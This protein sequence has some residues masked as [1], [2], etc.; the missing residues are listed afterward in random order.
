MTEGEHLHFLD[1]LLAAKEKTEK[2]PV[3][4]DGAGEG[5]PIVQRINNRR[6]QEGRGRGESRA[7]EAFRGVLE[8]PAFRANLFLASARYAKLGRRFCNSSAEGDTSMGLRLAN[9]DYS[10]ITMHERTDIE[11]SQLYRQERERVQHV[12]D[13]TQEAVDRTMGVVRKS[14]FSSD[15]R[16]ACREMRSRHRDLDYAPRFDPRNPEIRYL[17]LLS[18]AVYRFVKF[19]SRGEPIAVVLRVVCSTDNLIFLK[20]RCREFEIYINL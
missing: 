20:S 2:S 3:S 13:A 8:A 9:A 17:T 10:W 19:T 18:R 12:K 11:T 7:A 1:L 6:E 14:Y 4:R 16:V 5:E 15:L